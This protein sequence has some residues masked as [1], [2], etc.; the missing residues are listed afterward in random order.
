V[1]KNE[2]FGNDENLLIAKKKEGGFIL[3]ILKDLFY[4]AGKTLY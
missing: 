2:N 1:Q 3:D 4:S